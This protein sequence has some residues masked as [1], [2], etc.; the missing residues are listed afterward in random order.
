LGK[1]GG[2]TNAR[3]KTIENFFIK[4]FTLTIDPIL[5]VL[6]KPI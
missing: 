3:Q 2:G 6:L 1:G 5:I 4:Q